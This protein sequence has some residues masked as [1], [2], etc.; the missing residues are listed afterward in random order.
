MKYLFI[1]SGTADTEITREEARKLV[2]NDY[3]NGEEVFKML[4]EN[5]GDLRL[6][7]GYLRVEKEIK[8]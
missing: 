1:A 2:L 4:E 8:E 3:N 5:G 7:F 6:M